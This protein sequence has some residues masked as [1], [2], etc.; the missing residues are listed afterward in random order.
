MSEVNKKLER[1]LRVAIRVALKEHG[2][3]CDF[4]NMTKSGSLTVNLFDEIDRDTANFNLADKK[5]GLSNLGIKLGSKLKVIEKSDIKSLKKELVE[6]EVVSANPC[7][8]DKVIEVFN[9][10]SGKRKFMTISDVV[11]RLVN[12]ATNEELMIARG[13]WDYDDDGNIIKVKSSE[14]EYWDEMNSLDEIDE[15]DIV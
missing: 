7:A 10:V 4:G 8:R 13:E 14:E 11:Y 6:L 1:A 2:V 5:F 12:P 3:S 9:P 15:K